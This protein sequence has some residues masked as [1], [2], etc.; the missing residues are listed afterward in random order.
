MIEDWNEQTKESH[1]PSILGRVYVCIWVHVKA[2]FI[3]LYFLFFVL[4]IPY[5]FII[6]SSDSFHCSAQICY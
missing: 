2:L 4:D 1:T 5:C 6:N 3:L